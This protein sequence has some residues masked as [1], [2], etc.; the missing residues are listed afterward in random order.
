M[1][2]Y[3]DGNGT[4]SQ[5]MMIPTRFTSPRS[6]HY[7]NTKSPR[8]VAYIMA[9]K[10]SNDPFISLSFKSKQNGNSKF[11]WRHGGVTLK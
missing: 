1:R 5:T 3:S 11:E 2:P 6:M 9:A 10:S 8:S 4:K 7:D